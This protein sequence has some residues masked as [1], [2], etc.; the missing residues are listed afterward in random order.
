MGGLVAWL[1]VRVLCKSLCICV[2][3]VREVAVGAVAFAEVDVVL[4]V[5][6][7]EQVLFRFGAVLQLLGGFL[8]A[9]VRR[10]AAAGRLLLEAGAC[11]WVVV[12]GADRAC[13]REVEVGADPIEGA[14]GFG[15]LESGLAGFRVLGARVVDPGDGSAGREL[16]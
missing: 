4:A 6:F 16:E 13:A 1:L 7:A 8:G 5:L 14:R 12:L 15:A 2:V 10:L 11:L 3:D 9:A